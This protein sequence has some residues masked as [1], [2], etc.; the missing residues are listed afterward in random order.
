MKGSNDK[1]RENI[2]KTCGCMSLHMSV[3]YNRY[4]NREASACGHV[5]LCQLWILFISYLTLDLHTLK[6]PFLTHF[7]DSFF[8][9]DFIM[10]SY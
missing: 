9:S 6:N 4:A 8:I 10:I 1:L 2:R 5:V 7:S 3:S